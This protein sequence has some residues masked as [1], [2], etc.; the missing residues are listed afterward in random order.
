MR[1]SESESYMATRTTRGS[2]YCRYKNI[3]VYQSMHVMLITDK[4]GIS[5]S[6]VT[7]RSTR[8]TRGKSTV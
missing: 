4:I 6:T 5:E 8:L 3:A 1:I 2:S 7:T